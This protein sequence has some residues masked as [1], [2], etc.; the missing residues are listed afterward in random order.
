MTTTITTGILASDFNPDTSA[1][2]RMRRRWQVGPMRHVIAELAGARVIIVT[3]ARTGMCLTD[4]ALV[5]TRKTPHGDT[6]DVLVEHS[7]TDRKR[8]TWYPLGRLGELIIPVTRPDAKW[9]VLQRFHAEERA[10]I[11]WV[12]RAEGGIDWYIAPETGERCSWQTH[13]LNDAVH[14]RAVVPARSAARSKMP[15]YWRVPITE[16]TA[17]TESDAGRH[18]HVAAGTHTTRKAASL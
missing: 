3:D 18:V 4:V 5:A 16:L 7:C 11:N 9:A 14:V 17:V 13:T 12:K 2:D 1:S 6:F 15:K 8:G 10:A